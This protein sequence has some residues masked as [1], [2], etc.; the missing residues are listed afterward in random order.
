M[1]DKKMKHDWR[2]ILEAERIKNL[3]PLHNLTYFW[4]GRYYLEN[5]L[6]GKS[7]PAIMAGAFKN[8]LEN[9]PCPISPEDEFFGGKDCYVSKNLP[10]G[11]SEEQYQVAVK[12]DENKGRRD[13]VS[14]HS[15]TLP[16]YYE[17]VS[18]GIGGIIEKAERSLAKPR[19][20]LKQ[21]EFLTAVIMMM[22]SFSSYVLRSSQEAGR[23]GR[24]DIAERLKRISRKAP[25]NLHDAMQLIWITHV[26]LESEGR[27]H[28]ALGR[29]DQY[30]Y[31][32]YRKDLDRGVITN[33]LEIKWNPKIKEGGHSCPPTRGLENPRS[34]EE[35]MQRNNYEMISDE[36]LHL[37][38]HLWSKIEGFHEV[39]NICIG[40]LTP[41][42]KD[43]V[44]EL[45]YICL[46]ATKLARSPSTNLSA[47]FHDGSD[48]RYH[49]AC[50]DVIRSGIG[51]PA[52][53]NDHV[54][55]KSLENIGVPAEA[56][57]DYCMVGCIETMLAGRQQ[58]WGDSRF[59]LALVLSKAIDSAKNEKSSYEY[60]VKHFT[61]LFKKELMKH[62]EYINNIISSHPPG[63]F[64]DPLLSAFT[65]DCIGRAK[66]INDG[67]A[68]FRRFHG[69]GC[70]GLA[71]I[72]DS[73]SAMKKLVFEEKKI[74]FDDLVKALDADFAG[75][76]DMRLMLVNNVPK[77][78]NNDDYVDSI[79][80]WLVELFTSACLGHRT[81]DGGRFVANM[82]TN[83][84]NIP[85]GAEVK[86]T[87]DGRRAFTP[88]ADAASP[89]SGRDMKGPTAFINSVSAPDYSKTV[90]GTVINMKFDPEFFPGEKGA[91]CFLAITR[92]F[93]R[94]RIH[95]LQFNFSG[96]EILEAARKDP[97]KHAGL[98][99]RVSGFSAYFTRL[100]K[101]VQ[102]D[103]IRRR[104]HK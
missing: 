100:D 25:Q 5:E 95:E 62:V 58:A 1:K 47:R 83:I 104:V 22:E 34:V 38:C 17:I 20:S 42:G 19:R 80:A 45:T 59:N 88:L 91:E 87:P 13:F 89:N 64:P 53:F 28:N 37:F 76:E 3:D 21:K 18:L 72:A 92:E 33:S 29:I 70:V 67:G 81:V 35:K 60:F 9:L 69:I 44:N 85:C 31:P 50:G 4:R 97:E 8:A 78:G 36:A 39:T 73:L 63:K 96:N 101:K 6:T 86:A 41:E 12:A 71:N 52:I 77:Y 15:H 14:G 16:D 32:F 74:R 2:K 79:A 7:A 56:A 40:G 98:V 46:E 26:V 65:Q 61:E 66:D 49:L 23:A 24:K 94:K 68:V 82:A 55:V 51:F 84:Q 93:V 103:I 27:G 99:V 10:D 90:G 102:D 57:R 48:R 75:Y 54:T 11:I 43:A 30:L